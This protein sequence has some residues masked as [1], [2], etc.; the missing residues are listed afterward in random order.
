MSEIDS[1]EP[2]SVL[3]DRLAA[4]AFSRAELRTIIGTSCDALRREGARDSFNWIAAYLCEEIGYYENELTDW[5]R[6]EM[7]S[8][9]NQS[10]LT[11]WGEEDG[12]DRI[13]DYARE[14]KEQI[15]E[16]LA[17]ERPEG[18]MERSHRL[19]NHAMG[20]VR[21]AFEIAGMGM[22]EGVGDEMRSFAIRSQ[23]K[24][25]LSA[26]WKGN[27]QGEDWRITMEDSDWVQSYFVVRL[28]P[29]NQPPFIFQTGIGRHSK[30]DHES[31]EI[32]TDIGGSP[33]TIGDVASFVIPLAGEVRNGSISLI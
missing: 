11:V 32:D 31:F 12:P 30:T 16:D 21:S 22:V 28:F 24:E 4:A 33:P 3:P 18:W 20:V 9:G 1:L 7:R 5:F 10:P 29:P 27:G 13:F 15:D 8:L 26:R 25:G 6:S 14:I 19:G 2:V 23:G 17:S